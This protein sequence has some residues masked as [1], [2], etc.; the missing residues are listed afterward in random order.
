MEGCYIEDGIF[1]YYIKIFM[2]F[3]IV[4]KFDLGIRFLI[5]V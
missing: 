4:S 5:L 1:I 2:C 3:E